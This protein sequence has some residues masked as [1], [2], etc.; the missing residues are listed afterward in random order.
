MYVKF[1]L[2]EMKNKLNIPYVKFILNE[3]KNKF[4]IPEGLEQT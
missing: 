1:I 3:M 4:H 2:N